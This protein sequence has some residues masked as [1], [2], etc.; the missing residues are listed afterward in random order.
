MRVSVVDRRGQ[1]VRATLE[2]ETL[3]RTWCGRRQ[4]LHHEV[5]RVRRQN[6]IARRGNHARKLEEEVR[7]KRRPCG[8]RKRVVRICYRD[9]GN[10]VHR[11][12]EGVERVVGGHLLGILRGRDV[13]DQ[14]IR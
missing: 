8:R 12:V 7:V 6:N 4:I 14:Q 10:R 1:R 2:R 9:C 5:T 11:L 13:A 3:R